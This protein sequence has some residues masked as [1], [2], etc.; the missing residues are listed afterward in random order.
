M[1]IDFTQLPK[2]LVDTVSINYNQHH[3]LIALASGLEI[4]AFGMPPELMKAFAE[5]LP[6]K[7][8]EYESKFGKIEVGGTE[9]GI[10]SPIQIA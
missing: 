6:A 2:S 4:T 3:F 5:G 8:A 10:Q 7:I 9:G 1:N